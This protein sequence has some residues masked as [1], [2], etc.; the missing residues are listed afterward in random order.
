[1]LKFNR[2]R[3]NVVVSRRAVIERERTELKEQTLKVL[4]EG[5]VLE[6]VVKNIT[7]YGAFVDLGGLDGLLHITDMS[8]GRV[9][10]PSE[11]FKVGDKVK[12]VVLKYDLARARLARHEADH[13]RPVGQSAEKYP[14]GARFNGKVV[15]LTDYGAFV[16]LEKGVEGLIHVSEMCWSKRAVHPSK[17]VNVGDLVEARCSASTRPTGASRSG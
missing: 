12:V 16:E 13:G 15:S 7:D 10:H 3:G 17:V 9:R 1:M 6:G 4:E 8:W 14:V 5:K 2:K 11:L